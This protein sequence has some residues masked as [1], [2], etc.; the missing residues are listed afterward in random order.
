[1]P[2][3]PIIIAVVGMVMSVVASTVSMIQQKKTAEAT[4]KYKSKVLQAQADQQKAAIEQAAQIMTR[5]AKY[6][7]G[8]MRATGAAMGLGMGG[9]SFEDVTQ[10][11]IGL[12]T[13]DIENKRYE[14]DLAQWEA[15]VQKANAEFERNATVT[16]ANVGI[17][18]N[19]IGG[20][21]TAMKDNAGS[22]ASSFGNKRSS[23]KGLI[24]GGTNTSAGSV[25]SGG[26]MIA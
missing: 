14:A 15:D 11:N 7:Q 16:T 19:I 22:I 13:M 2:A 17:A 9:S 23:T 1:M 8:T 10:M 12:A 24:S 4:Y 18:A 21:G 6:Q 20:F 3:A 25:V 26:S 5:Q